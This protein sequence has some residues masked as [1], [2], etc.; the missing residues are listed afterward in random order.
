MPDKDRPCT[1]SLFSSPH[2]SL[3]SIFRA[4]PGRRKLTEAGARRE[5]GRRKRGVKEGRPALGSSGS[6]GRN[7]RALKAIY[8]PQGVGGGW[9]WVR[10]LC[11]R[12]RKPII[13]P[14]ILSYCGA[15]SSVTI[16]VMQT[17]ASHQRNERCHDSFLFSAATLS[18]LRSMATQHQGHC[19]KNS[20]SVSG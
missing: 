13:Q 5:R 20:C 3:F 15:Q 19:C 8:R 6:L 9:G 12:Q 2:P 14:G 4:P 7:R 16:A 10:K 17:S 18:H 1:Q 11:S